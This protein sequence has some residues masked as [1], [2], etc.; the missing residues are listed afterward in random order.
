MG[1]TCRVIR[2]YQIIAEA[3]GSLQWPVDYGKG[4]GISISIELV[5]GKMYDFAFI[6]PIRPIRRREA[7]HYDT[8]TRT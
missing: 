4:E 3:D 2:E 8:P 7:N 5:K 6:V 1:R